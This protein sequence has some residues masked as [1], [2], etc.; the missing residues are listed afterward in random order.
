M[1]SAD[2]KT[3]IEETRESLS[4]ATGVNSTIYNFIY[5]P[6]I[7]ILNSKKPLLP[8]TELTLTFD[9][10]PA[11]LALINHTIVE[12]DDLAGSVL[13]LKNVSLIANY[14]SSPYLRTYF[15]TITQSPIS[16]NYDEVQVYHKN[17]PTGDNVIRLSNIIGGNT[18]R[19]LFCGIIESDALNGSLTKCSSAFKRHNVE[20]FD[21]TLN[22]YSCLGFPLTNIDTAPVKVYDKFLSTTNRKFQVQCAEQLKPRDFKN[23]HF[24]YSHRFEGENTETGWIGINIKLDTAYASNMTLGKIMI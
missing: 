10:A 13:T 21:L 22:G 5:R 8:K 17:L 2:A 19:Y 12:K 15:D 9:R 18:P 1:S 7:G 14:Y 23:F 4:D 20:Q 11:D 24:L 16:Y 6:P 3:E